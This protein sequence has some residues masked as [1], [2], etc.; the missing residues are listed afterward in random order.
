MKKILSI[1]MAIVVVISVLGLCAFAGADATVKIADATVKAGES[2]TVNVMLENCDELTSLSIKL[3]YDN[4]VLKLVDGKCLVDNPTLHQVDVK[5][6]VALFKVD[7]NA[8]ANGNIFELNFNV[9][10]KANAGSYNISIDRIVIKQSTDTNEV[11]LS[12]NTESGVITVKG[13][14][15]TTAEPTDTSTTTTKPADTSTTT[16]EPADTSTT[17]KPADTSTTTTKPADKPTTTKPADKPTTTKPAD[18]PTTTKPA[19]KPTTTE[20]SGKP[21]TTKPSTTKP[22]ADDSLLGDLNGDKKITASDARQI[23][24]V[25]AKLDKISDAKMTIADI[26]GNKK[27]TASDARIALRIS[28]KLEKIEDYMSGNSGATTTKPATADVKIN[29]ADYLN[30]PLKN[31][32]KVVPDLVESKDDADF[33]SNK[34]CY[35]RTDES[36]VIYE[37]GLTAKSAKGFSATVEGVSV[38]IKYTDADNILSKNGYYKDFFNSATN[39]EKDV[40]VMYVEEGGKI[41]IISAY[42]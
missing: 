28:A 30:K 41:T 20:P 2:F 16:T 22:V 32:T 24:R 23:L 35:I 13:D 14:E 40:M 9:D 29:L 18:K 27:V 37:V 3:N 7:G 5:N 17:T 1:F 31:F 11:D 34:W 12:A 4:S 6:N 26:D 38:G 25:S 42:V 21:T 36:G 19:D 15:V 33:Y 8:D 10:S 39:A